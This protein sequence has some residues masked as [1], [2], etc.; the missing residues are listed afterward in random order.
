MS[1]FKHLW[2]QRK[3]SLSTW[4]VFRDMVRGMLSFAGKSVTVENAIKVSAVFSCCRVIGEGVAQV[5]LKLMQVSKDGKKRVPAVDH[6]LYDVLAN[7]PNGWQTSFEY[8]EM[9]AWHVVLCG[10]A[11]S[12]INR[13]GSGNILELIPFEPG[14]V[15]VKR[16]ED[17]SLTYE[18][19]G[20]NGDFQTF[21]QDQIWHLRGP[22]WNGW[23]ALSPVTLAREA[24]GLAM[25]TEESVGRLHSNG[26]R[27]SGMYS[28][29]GSLNETQHASLEKWVHENNAG[30]EN[31][32]KPLILDRSAKWINTQMSGVDAQ[33]LETRKFQIEEICRFARV[34]PIMVG[35]SDK[36]ATFASAEQMF[37][38]HVVH[39]LAPWYTRFEQSIDANLL[40]DKDRKAGYYSNFVEEGMMRGSLKDTKDYLLGLVNG[41]LMTPNEGRGKLDLNPDDDPESDKLRIPANIVGTVPDAQGATT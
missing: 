8:R 16:A 37:L 19:R 17:W 6:P 39:T 26:V 35:Y 36:A 18:V 13:S 20:K 28:V 33:S 40:T 7:R 34:L 38:A 15:T 30:V 14:Q 10:Q 2:P 22:S 41:G 31:T 5:P 32:G 11:F 27:P 29:E 3:K 4:D 9:L 24:I 1:I 23:Q 21:K 25:A 12:F